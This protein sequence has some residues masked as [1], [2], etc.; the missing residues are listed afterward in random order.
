MKSVV[1][2]ARRSA[3][4]GQ[5]GPGS[6]DAALAP[7]FSEGRWRVPSRFNFT[8]DVVEALARDPKRQALTFVARDGIIEPRSF[9][10][11][12][13]GAA[14]WASY[15]REHGVNPGDRVLVVLSASPDWLEIVLACIKVGAVAVP[16]A[17]TLPAAALEIRVAAVGA[18]VVVVDGRAAAVELAPPTGHV[19]I[20][21]V[22]KARR[23]AHRLP[24]EGPTANTS[25]NDPA[26]VVWTTGRTNGPRGA[27]HT[28]QATFAARHHAEHW[29][30]AGPGDIVWCSAPSHSAQALWSSLFGP[31]S[32]GAEIVLNEAPLD[33]AEEIELVRRLRVTT[34]CRTPGE[35]AFLAESNRLERVRSERLR[36]LV[37]TGN[38]L[39]EVLVEIVE[40]HTGLPIHDGYGQ[41]ETGVIVG[42]AVDAVSPRGS[43]GRPLPGYD[44]AVID[45]GGRELPPGHLGDIALRGSPP[46]L[47]AG[48]WDAP[49]STKTAFRGEWYVTGDVGTRDDAGFFW[50]AGRAGDVSAEKV[51]A[52]HTTSSPVTSSAVTLSPVTSAAKL[53]PSAEA[54]PE[55]VAEPAPEPA[56]QTVEAPVVPDPHGELETSPPASDQRLPIPLW[57]RVTAAI[58][59]LLLGIL[60]GGA[61]IPHASDEPRIEPQHGVPPNSICLPPAPRK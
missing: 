17:E 61:A 23:E 22:D 19:T 18:K 59:L 53:A 52:A 4:A 45:A 27:A 54:V 57:A 14:R 32:R 8:R 28:H 26:L 10:Q 60:I 41:A 11:I 36:R 16:C 1:F 50:L 29:L 12:A 31:W 3:Q 40:E 21:N 20:L 46:S 37:A 58:W 35:Y 34:L 51:T 15:L 2:G 6:L 25:G 13:H 24:K 9:L 44:V 30:D 55:T 47:F 42:H 33:P 38:P 39:P 5:D 7:A 48:Y 49:T 56:R 43:I